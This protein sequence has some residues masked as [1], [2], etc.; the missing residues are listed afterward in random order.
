MHALRDFAAQEIG[1]RHARRPGEQAANT[2][3]VDGRARRIAWGR[4][5]GHGKL[6]QG[7]AIMREF[8]RLV[9]C[10]LPMLYSLRHWSQRLLAQAASVLPASCALCGCAARE[11]LCDGCRTQ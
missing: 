2:A 9:T 7:N 1:L 6:V 3:H 10:P 5:V 4:N 8:T 11:T